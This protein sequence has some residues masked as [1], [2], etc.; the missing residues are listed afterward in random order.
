M[1][2]TI[3][4]NNRNYT[5]DLSKPLDISIPISGKKQNVIAWGVDHPKIG[6]HI[7]E[8]YEGSVA[9]G[10]A[11]NFNDIKFNPHAHGTHTECYGHITKEVHSVNKVFSKY[12][13]KAEVITIAPE[14]YQDDFVISKKQ[15]RYAVGNKKREAIII[16]TLPNTIQKKRKHYSNSNP[17]YLLEE[18]AKYLAEIGVDHLLIDL[19]SVDREEDFGAL[20]AHRAFWDMDGN[21]R[22]QA[23]I[24]E[25]IFVNNKILDGTYFVSLQ[26]GPFEN[27]AAPSRPVLYA[28]QE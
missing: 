8:D 19:P 14:K 12:F 25:L 11:V 20:L 28:I 9:A 7:S 27:D 22:K 5:I 18:A 4:H 24:T 3:R 26:L 17:P 16:R 10:E 13:F 15:L 23:T 6:P 2:T 21:V 1:T